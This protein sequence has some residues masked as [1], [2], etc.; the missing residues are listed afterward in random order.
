MQQ[1]GQPKQTA[2]VSTVLSCILHPKQQALLTTLKCYLPP[3]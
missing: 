2:A 3:P 1:A